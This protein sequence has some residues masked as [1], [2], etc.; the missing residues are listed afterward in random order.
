MWDFIKENCISLVALII[1]LI[2]FFK[3]NIKEIITASK[4]K[5]INNSAVIT[6]SYINEKLIISNKGKSNAENIRIFIDDEDITKNSI[7]GVFAKNMNFS[8]LSPNNSFGI[9]HIKSFGMKNSFNIKVI[10]EDNNSKNNS[11]EDIINL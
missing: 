6:V 9:K 5:K 11:V 2:S 4:N 10:W 1:S 8:L 7:F 3:D